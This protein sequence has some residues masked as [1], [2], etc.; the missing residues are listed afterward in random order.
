MLARLRSAWREL[1][2]AP[3][4]RRFQQRFERRRSRPRS[5]LRKALWV[6]ASILVIAIG[7]IALPLPGPGLLIIALGALPIAEES[8]TVARRLDALELWL[9]RRLRSSGRPRAPRR[10]IL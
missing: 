3:P 1:R 10:G 4:G 7:V 6:G 8:R 9:R 2:E 5:A